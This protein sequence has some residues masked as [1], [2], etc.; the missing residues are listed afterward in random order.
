[1]ALPVDSE[2]E[3]AVNDD[4]E[5]A[6]EGRAHGFHHVTRRG[7]GRVLENRTPAREVGYIG[8]SLLPN[9]VIRL[10]TA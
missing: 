1:M 9:H 10:S 5:E 2:D 6:E 8:H 3:D 4:D 7:R